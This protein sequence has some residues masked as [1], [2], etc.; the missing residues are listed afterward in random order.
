MNRIIR[1]NRTSAVSITGPE[2]CP[3]EP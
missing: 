1:S 2:P 3:Q